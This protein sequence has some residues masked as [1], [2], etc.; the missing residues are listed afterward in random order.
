MK[1]VSGVRLHKQLAS[2]ILTSLL[3]VL[4]CSS[5]LHACRHSCFPLPH[6]IIMPEETDLVVLSESPPADTLTL[7]A[8]VHTV[9]SLSPVLLWPFLVPHQPCH[10]NWPVI[11]YKMFVHIQYMCMCVLCMHSVHIYLQISLKNFSYSLQ[12]P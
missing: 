8:V 12:L 2:C 1:S 6:I 3:C 9:S 5:Y 4:F 10:T 7:E 11:L